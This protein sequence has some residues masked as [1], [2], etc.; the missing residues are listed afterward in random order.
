MESNVD[1]AVCLPDDLDGE[2]LTRRLKLRLTRPGDGAATA[3]AVR[4]SLAELH[5]WVPAATR[6]ADPQRAEWCAWGAWDRSQAQVA[7]DFMA[8][9][10]GDEARMVARLNMAPV[11]SGAF[12]FEIT[13]WR[14]TAF[15]GQ[16]FLAESLRALTALAFERLDA[17]RVYIRCDITDG[18]TCRAAE[19]AGL[20]RGADA[21][22]DATPGITRSYSLDLAR[23]E[24]IQNERITPDGQYML[25]PPPP[26]PTSDQP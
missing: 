7:Y 3:Q 20:L 21:I 25:A 17:E 5:L 26:G 11:F 8:F 18:P 23:Y 15:A 22:N 14:S 10:R 12:C 13:C 19:G 2:I 6:W 9:H 24:A 16:G 4:E 1:L